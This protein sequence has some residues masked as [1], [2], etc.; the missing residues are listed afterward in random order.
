[1]PG[2]QACQKKE[3]KEK[4]KKNLMNL[5]CGEGIFIPDEDD[6]KENHGKGEE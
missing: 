3:K 6:D 1:M 5:Q 4:E 2:K